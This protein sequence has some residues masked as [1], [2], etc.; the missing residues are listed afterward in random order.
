MQ[1]VYWKVILGNHGREEGR[2]GWER[3][4]LNICCVIKKASGQMGLGKLRSWC[5]TSPKFYMKC[6]WAKVFIQMP[7]NLWLR[8]IAGGVSFPIFS[9]CPLLR[10]RSHLQLQKKHP[11]EEYQILIVENTKERKS[12]NIP[13][14][15]FT[16]IL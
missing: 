6:K 16:E 1:R 15:Q 8:N 7:E 9:A 5:K 14:W 10:H 11:G 4:E 3:K 13:K 2:W 12:P